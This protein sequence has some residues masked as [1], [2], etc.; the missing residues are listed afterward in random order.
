MKNVTAVSKLAVHLALALALAAL[1]ASWLWTIA[2]PREI[3]RGTAGEAATISADLAAVGRLFGT[4][5]APSAAAPVNPLADVLLKGVY[6][7]RDGEGGFV[8]V[9]IGNQPP[10]PVM[11]GA[12]IRPGLKLAKLGPDHAVFVGALGE[13][14]LELPVRPILVKPAPK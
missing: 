2:G 4:A 10:R 11:A 1:C 7:A 6:R 14:R 5:V 3:A 9:Q 12:E 13:T 8:V